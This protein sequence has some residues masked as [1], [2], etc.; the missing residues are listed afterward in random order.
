MNPRNASALPKWSFHCE[1]V[2]VLLAHPLHSLG[3][4]NHLPGLLLDHQEM[5][6]AWT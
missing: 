3:H 2:G 5:K 6:N 4:P 1:G